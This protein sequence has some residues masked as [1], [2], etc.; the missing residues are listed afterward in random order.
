MCLISIKIL[1]TK[2]N[3]FCKRNI[4]EKWFYIKTSYNKIRIKFYKLANNNESFIVYSLVAI[5][6]S[7]LSQNFA[8]L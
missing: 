2:A 3:S 8:N 6:F 4:G 1:D 7:N 5:G